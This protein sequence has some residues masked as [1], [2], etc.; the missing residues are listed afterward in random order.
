MCANRSG[1]EHV[2]HYLAHYTHRVAISNHRLIGMEG[3]QV[4]FRWNMSDAGI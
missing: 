3:G 2:L 4:T 1:P